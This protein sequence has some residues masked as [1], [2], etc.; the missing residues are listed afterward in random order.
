MLEGCRQ[1]VLLGRVEVCPPSYFGL[2]FVV[3]LGVQSTNGNIRWEDSLRTIDHEE[4]GVAGGLTS[5]RAQ[6]PYYSR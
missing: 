4:G 1:T 6:P 3:V 2:A 5:L